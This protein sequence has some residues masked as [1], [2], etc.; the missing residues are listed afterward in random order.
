MYC[1]IKD[2]ENMRFYCTAEASDK[3]VLSVYHTTEEEGH[4]CRFLCFPAC[5]IPYASTTHNE[6][7]LPSMLYAAVTIDIDFEE[8][9]SIFLLFNW[10]ANNICGCARELLIF[11]LPQW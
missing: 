5:L 8:K 1:H 4:W 6:T 3:F 10:N 9:T 11:F 7:Q 2:T